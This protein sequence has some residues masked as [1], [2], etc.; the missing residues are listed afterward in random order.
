[1]KLYC[2]Q[3]RNREPVSTVWA[4]ADMSQWLC[5]KHKQREQKKLSPPEDEEPKEKKT[6]YV[7]VD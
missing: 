1:M 2:D 7:I 3:C 5:A 4:S 6:K